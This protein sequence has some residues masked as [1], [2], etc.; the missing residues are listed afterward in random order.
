[1]TLFYFVV[2]D[3]LAIVVTLSIGSG[4]VADV[5]TSRLVVQKAVSVNTL[6]DIAI[7][8]LTDHEAW[9]ASKAGEYKPLN[10]GIANKELSTGQYLVGVYVKL[11]A[12]TSSAKFTVGV[13]NTLVASDTI[14][15][16]CAEHNEAVQLSCPG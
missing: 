14:Q 5:A 6:Q 4:S 15:L 2:T 13:T 8:S 11:K 9:A 7:N 3:S 1:M 12:D 16:R 10:I